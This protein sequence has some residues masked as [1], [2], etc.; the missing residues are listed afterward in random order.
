MLTG[1][2]S[3]LR[4]VIVA[5]PQ[6][7]LKQFLDEIPPWKLSTLP[8]KSL[9]SLSMSSIALFAQMSLGRAKAM[10]R[11]CSFL[12]HVAVYG[13]PPGGLV[14]ELTL[15]LQVLCGECLLGNIQEQERES[16]SVIK[17][18]W[19]PKSDHFDKG[20]Q[21]ACQI[22]GLECAICYT[23]SA[24]EIDQGAPQGSDLIRTSC[25][26]SCSHLRYR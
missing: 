13:I 26:K 14:N 20:K 7:S 6:V 19:C 3:H 23:P 12:R 15:S 1:I 5:N 9:T 4:N 2:R 22:F 24:D 8:S 17:D 11:A 10:S 18:V 16:S 25:G 21:E